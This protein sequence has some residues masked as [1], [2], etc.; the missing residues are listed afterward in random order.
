MGVRITSDEDVCALFDSVSGWAFGPTFADSDEAESFLKFLQKN[1][2]DDARA[3]TQ[4][5][6]GDW[7]DK[8]LAARSTDVSS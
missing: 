4:V 6:L 5:E 2:A 7:H 3:L 1:D 8:W